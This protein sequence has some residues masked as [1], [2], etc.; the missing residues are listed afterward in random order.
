MPTSADRASDLATDWAARVRANR[1]QV[2]AYRE[3]Q[4][5]RDFYRPTSSL[6]R[7]DPHRTDDPIL[8]ALL[9]LARP[10]DVW[11]DIGAGAGRFAL[12]LAL[13][14]REVIAIDP[15]EGMLN[16]LR[17]DMAESGIANVRVI[18]GRWPADADGLVADVSLI[19][20]VSYD[21]EEI[22]PFIRA[23]EAATRRLCVAVLMEQAPSA[24]AA[25]FWPPVHGVERV[26]LP[27][28]GELVA[29]L[30]ARG[31]TVQVR[32]LPGEG[33]RWPTRDDLAAALRHQLWVNPDSPKGRRLDE[34]V[35]ALPRDDEG[36]IRLE[37]R[38]RDIG[39]VTWTPA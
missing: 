35:D 29:L 24:I 11:L 12:P 17:S 19:A 2:D 26:P 6:F 28:L 31:Q 1:E 13:S 4:D 36:G 10:D 30:E 16:G 18:H 22:D 27:A 3:V 37:A 5:D 7:A 25:P 34:A 9:A 23:M 33:R 32:R 20:H 38:N 21:V 39:I 15:S 8:S 14:V